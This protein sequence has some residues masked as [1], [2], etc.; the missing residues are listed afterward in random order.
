MQL[1][2]LKP[3]WRTRGFHSSTVLPEF[4]WFLHEIRG[5]YGPAPSQERTLTFTI[6][7]TQ[8]HVFFFKCEQQSPIFQPFRYSSF[9]YWDKTRELYTRAVVYQVVLPQTKAQKW[10]FGPPARGTAL[11]RA[12]PRLLTQENAAGKVSLP[13]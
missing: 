7:K 12:F 6:N 3:S 8:K 2:V 1:G 9:H 5:C 10:H 11:H 4:I 13:S